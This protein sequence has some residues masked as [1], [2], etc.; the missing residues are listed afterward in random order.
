MF[1]CSFTTISPS[2]SSGISPS[3]TSLMSWR[4]PSC[5]CSP[6]AGLLEQLLNPPPAPLA[7]RQGVR[8]ISDAVAGGRGSREPELRAAARGRRARAQPRGWAGQAPGGDATAGPAR[9][10]R[11]WRGSRRGM[12]E[13]LRGAAGLPGGAAALVSG[14]R[15][16]APGAHPGAHPGVSVS[17]PRLSPTTLVARMQCPRQFTGRVI[18]LPR[19][20]SRVTLAVRA[21]ARDVVLY[22][23]IL[24]VYSTLQCQ[25][26]NIPSHQPG[27]LEYMQFLYLSISSLVSRDSWSICNMQFS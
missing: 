20:A 1:T 23:S 11:G 3:S 8:R 14:G 6:G 10:A 12:A 26:D 15:R 5:R 13:G 7:R 21:D 4:A 25:G 2:S 17:T 27:W 19:L 9:V 18:L 24:A 16:A 22:L